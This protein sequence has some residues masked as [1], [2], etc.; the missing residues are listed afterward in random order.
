MKS[1]V[2]LLV[3]FAILA[4]VSF[5][6]VDAWPPEYGTCYITCGETQYPFQS[7][8]QECCSGP[9]YCPDGSFATFAYWEPYYGWPEICT[10]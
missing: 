4:M 9:H 7:T 6:N 10:Y 5:S 3:L 8:L 2:R 1:L